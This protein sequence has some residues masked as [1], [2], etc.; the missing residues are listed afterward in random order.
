MPHLGDSQP[1]GSYT[2]RH[3]RTVRILKPKS[4]SRTARL[5]LVTAV[6]VAIVTLA[7]WRVW[8]HEDDVAPPGRRLIDVELTW[9][10]EA[11]HT[12][13]AA[14]Q[15]LPRQCWI[16]DRQAFPLIVMYCPT[17]GAFD[18]L[19]R[20]AP[21]TDNVPEVAQLKLVGYRW[22]DAAEGLT[23]PRCREKLIYKGPDPLARVTRQNKKPA[24]G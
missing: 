22:V 5:S 7:L 3:R 14:G 10:C 11:G 2:G 6:G 1:S 16:C 4:A 12:F 13:Q 17:H 8:R 19:V 20:F 18:V 15:L 21:G 23:C 24:G 9:R